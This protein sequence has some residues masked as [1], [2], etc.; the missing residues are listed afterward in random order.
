MFNLKSG[1]V[2]NK[3][4]ISLDRFQSLVSPVARQNVNYFTYKRYAY[5]LGWDLA[6]YNGEQM[7]SRFGGF[8]GTTLHLSFIPQRGVGIIAFCNE[9]KGNR[10]PHISAN[11][12][13][14]LLFK[15]DNTGDVFNEEKRLYWKGL[16]KKSDPVPAKANDIQPALKISGRYESNGGWPLIDISKRRD[17]EWWIKWGDSEAKAVISNCD[18]VTTLYADF[19][20]FQ[21]EFT[22]KGTGRRMQ[23]LETGSLQYI[24]R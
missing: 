3:V 7:V 8:S 6:Q 23:R 1:L 19:G 14:N 18:S 13:Y 2:N 12:A 5:S 4:L 22:I 15:K 11:L 20:A 16:S 17:G 21:R 10:L 24:R 9:E